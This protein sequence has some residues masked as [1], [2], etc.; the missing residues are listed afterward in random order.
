MQDQLSKHYEIVGIQKGGGVF[1]R[2]KVRPS[3]RVC[4]SL[5]KLEM[6]EMNISYITENG[7]ELFD[8]IHQ[9]T[10]ETFAKLASDMETKTKKTLAAIMKLLVSV[11]GRMSIHCCACCLL[12]FLCSP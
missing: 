8:A 3:Y 10:R 1:D 6:Q 5:S 2:M 11:L 4:R 12:T 9:D 7:D